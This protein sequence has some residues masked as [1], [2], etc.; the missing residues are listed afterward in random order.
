M[1]N[2]SYARIG[3]GL[4]FPVGTGK[5]RAAR[6]ESQHKPECKCFVCKATA[7]RKAKKE[8]K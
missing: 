7:V 8:S 5:P 6:S 4:Y 2:T 1:A 3:N